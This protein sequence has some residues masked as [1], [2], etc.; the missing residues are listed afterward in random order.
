MKVKVERYQPDPP[1]VK[2]VNI[3]LSAA[4]ASDLLAVCGNY[5]PENP[6]RKLCDGIRAE[7]AS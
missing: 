3:E 2:S 7:L 5:K 6:A 4:E 1:P